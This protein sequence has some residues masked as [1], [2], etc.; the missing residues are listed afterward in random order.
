ML[1]GLWA[2][3]W[4]ISFIC[5]DW[6]RGGGLASLQTQFRIGRGPMQMASFCKEARETQEKPSKV[7]DAQRQDRQIAN[8]SNLEHS[9]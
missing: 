9:T 8:P 4:C 3:T 1:R 5:N 7:A 2:T 6:E